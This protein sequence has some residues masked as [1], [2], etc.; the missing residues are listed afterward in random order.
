MKLEYVLITRMSPTSSARNARGGIKTLARN[1]PILCFTLLAYLFGWIGFAPLVLTNIGLGLIHRDIGIE[2]IVP[3]TFAPTLAAALTHWLSE[4]SFRFARI[5]SVAQRM[6]LGLVVGVALIVFGFSALPAVFLARI[7]LQGIHWSA[8][9]TSSAYV[10]NWSIFFAG[11]VGEE[12]GWRGFA[13]PRLQ[14]RFGPSWGSVLLGLI[15]AGWHLPLFLVHGW[16]SVPVWGFALILVSVSILIT[17]AV[18]RSRGSVLVAILLHSTFNTS[19]SIL[20]A[21]THD[22]PTREP[23]LPYYLCAVVTTALVTLLATKGRLGYS[24]PQQDRFRWPV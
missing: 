7:P 1:H 4:H 8:F 16:V 22:V 19:S 15:W 13:L 11:P 2:W 24:H 18:N 23:D 9:L 5:F 14:E 17:Y 6:L 3:G 20:A 10:L 12:P 21:L